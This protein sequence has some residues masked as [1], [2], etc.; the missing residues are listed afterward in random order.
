MQFDVVL[1]TTRVGNKT[2]ALYQPTTDD[3]ELTTRAEGMTVSQR[4]I[5]ANTVRYFCY[6]LNGSTIASGN[7]PVMTLTFEPQEKLVAG[8]YAINIQNISLGTSALTNKY[9]GAATVSDSFTVLDLLLGDVN[10]DGLRNV[11]DVV[12]LI[13]KIVGNESEHFIEA[14]ANMNGDKDINVQDVVILINLIVGN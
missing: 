8:D 7:G 2:F 6:F 12:L 5:D 3:I 14:A 10:G 9:A 4:M 13:N 11:Q 1:P